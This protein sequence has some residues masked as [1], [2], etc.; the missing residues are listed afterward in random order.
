MIVLMS[1]F[2]VS[3][4]HSMT[5]VVVLMYTSVPRPEVMVS[6]DQPV[7]VAGS[8][9]SLTC[10]ITQPSSE[11]TP[12]TT[13]VTFSWTVPD[14]VDYTNSSVS[15]TSEELMLVSVETADSG[16][17]TCSATL[18]DS[19]DSDY[20]LDSEPATAVASVTISKML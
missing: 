16:D 3:C 18:T 11:T 12:T 15:E 13:D 2:R 19:T 9:L 8:S 7:L 6:P 20:I 10:S 17:Y 1:L 5:G 14:G 4:F